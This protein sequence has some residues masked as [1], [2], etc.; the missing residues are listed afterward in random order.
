MTLSVRRIALLFGCLAVMTAGLGSV[1]R[2]LRAAPLLP[3]GFSDELVASVD[4]PTAIAFTPDGRML[5]TTQPG[6]LRVV[7]GGTLVPSPAVD[8][9]A[10]VCA[11]SERGLLG[12]AVDPS[13]ATNH[14]IYLYY[15]FKNHSVCETNTANAPV[16]RVSRFVLSDNNVVD[17]SREDILIDN[18]PSPAGNHNGGDL[19]FGKDGYLYVSVGDGGCDYAG[20]G[21]AGANDAARDQHVL[22]GKVLRV[23]RD[24]G[25]PPNNPF[26]GSDSARCNSTGRTTPGNKCRETFAWGLRNPFRMA[27]DPNA[28]STRFYINDVGQNAWEEI[29]LGQPGADYGWNIRE[30][31][32]TTGSSTVCDNPPAGMTNPLY[33]YNHDSGCSSITGG[34]FVPNGVWPS[35]YDGAYLFADYVCGT[36]FRLEPVGVGQFT[37][38]AFATGLGGSSAVHLTFGPWNGSQA[39]YYTT[40]ASGGQIRRI[41]HTAGN[42]SPVASIDASPTSGSAPLTVSFDGGSSSDPDGDALTSY[43][44]DFGDGSGTTTTSPL[45]THA[46][47]GQGV[48]TATLRVRDGRGATSAPAQVQI[49][50]DS[51]APAPAIGAPSAGSTFAVG[52][53]ITLIGRADDAEDGSLQDESFSW[54]VLIHHNDHTHPLVQS[55]TGNNVTFRAPAPED[56]AATATSYV[57]IRLTATDSH[58]L[59]STVT[60]DFRPRRVKITFR[61]RPRGLRLRVNG[62]TLGKTTTL[63]SWKG[64]RLNVNAPS[65]QRG[66]VFRSW[67]DGGA[68]SHTIVTPGAA[69][70]YTARYKR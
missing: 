1:E 46:Y 6:T 61:T 3:S 27:F 55:A 32:C 26:Q 50:V 37:R 19:H 15:T 33:D 42:T 17:P 59:S 68:Q 5:V 48:F 60:R 20:S 70:T 16:N 41:A 18:I 64:Y 29:D 57:E 11:N 30:G 66:Y 36:I 69:T 45:V 56:L 40:Y 8:L 53:K 38:S 62:T 2:P 35:I 31:H 47:S 10:R 13:F 52:E 12:V 24:G 9:S 34:A 65:P 14:Y 28:S 67:S 51:T 44:W 25:I 49:A 54:N 22:V 58:G 63:T 43:E 7:Q 4:A 23:T 21:C 39:L